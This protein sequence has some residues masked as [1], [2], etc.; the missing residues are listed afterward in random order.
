MLLLVTFDQRGF[1]QSILHQ[2]IKLRGAYGSDGIMVLSHGMDNFS[3]QQN[4]L[5]SIDS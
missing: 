1:T 3:D 5:L 4:T 2:S